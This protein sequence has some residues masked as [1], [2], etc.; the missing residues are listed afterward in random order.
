MLEFLEYKMRT[1]TQIVAHN[2]A[3]FESYSKD[4]GKQALT[5]PIGLAFLALCSIA[6]PKKK[7]NMADRLQLLLNTDTQ[8]YR[9]FCIFD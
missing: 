1:E 9:D 7:K 2:L 4:K 3:H 8:G 5:K 6:P